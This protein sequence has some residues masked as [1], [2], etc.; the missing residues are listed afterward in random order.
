MAHHFLARLLSIGSAAILGFFSASAGAA[1]NIAN[2]SPRGLTI[3]KPTV[4]V[5][6]GTD[7]TPNTRL[8]LPATIASQTIKSE[9]Q[10]DRLEIEVT[11]DPA[12]PPGLYPLRLAGGKGISGPVMIGV[13]RL[14]QLPFAQQLG[15][16]PV[17][18]HGTLAGT[19]VL[20]ARF[21]GQKD[22]RLVL[23][24][25]AQRLGSSLEPVVRLYD[26]R[27][28]QIA[29][30]PPLPAIG[31]D[32]RC[33]VKLPA[34]GEYSIELHERL[35]RA[36]GPAFFRLKIGDL[37]YADLALPLA[38]AAGSKQA[39]QFASTNLPTGAEQDATGATVPGETVAALPAAENFTGAAPRLAIT[40][41]PE[42][43]ESAAT[44]GKLQELPACPVG[45]SGVLAAKG[46]EDKYLLTVTPGQKL[47]LDVIARQVGSPL[48][49]VL[50]IR[51]EQGKQLATGDDRPAS[52]DPLVDFEVP[53]NVTKLQIALKDLNGSG[54]SEFVYRIDIQDRSRPDFAL[55]LP[56]DRVNVPAGGAQVVPVQVTRTNYAG[57]IELSLAGRPAELT[58]AGN[59]IPPG[60][61]IGLLTLS[62]GNGPPQ[63]VL[64]RVVGKALE[65]PVPVV[66]AA[67]F[68][69]VPGGR[70]QPR[71]REQ[72]GL[73]IAEASPINIVWAPSESDKLMLG[74]KLVAKLQLPRAAGTAGS[75]RVRLLTTQPMPK[76]TVKENNQDKVVDD[77][78]RALRLEGDP[79]FPADQS[80]V[81][82]NILV[83]ADLPRQAWD[84]VLVADLLS[85]DGKNTVASIAAP[86][87]RLSAAVPFTLEL[88]GPAN[89]EG[90]AGAGET[91]KFTGK[92]V[93][94]AGYDQ[95]VTVTLDNLPK[96]LSSPTVI[97][98]ADQSEFALPVTFAFGSKPGE[99]KG[100]KLVALS[101]PVTTQSVRS[102]AVD[103]AVSVVPGEK[104]AA[105]QPKEIF[106]DDE[107]FI[108]LLT[109]GAGRAIP[110]M[111]DKHSGTYSLRVTGDQK[112]N[113]KLPT[114]GMKIRENPAPGEYR[115]IRFAWKKAGGN[116]ICLQL[117]HDGVWGPGGEGARE[118]AKFRYHAG[119]GGE[120]Y[121]AS[122]VISDKLPRQFQVV[123][124]D[125]FADFGEFTLTGLAFSPVDGNAAL[126]DHLYLGRQLEDFT[127][128]KVEKK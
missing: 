71:I 78:D 29:W 96:G 27:G 95:P 54:G 45:I 5:I 97:V 66:R 58:L 16:F 70:Y 53:A 111:R 121:G 8:L 36:A 43:V 34:D 38:V 31:G 107:K 55:S 23:D 39:L 122:L 113:P 77:L 64:S 2:V 124:R 6:T 14:P 84:L 30:S 101:S 73:A 51:D 61:T 83:P 120:C 123:T 50:L 9:A 118:G 89:V 11:L 56:A 44:D 102:N 117:N 28:K 41:H 99:L 1:P 115:Y 40:D 88:A 127:L 109:E 76:K 72:I 10:P 105:E 74:G 103:V 98:P 68:G 81:A 22:Q 85:A 82:V 12:V 13:D 47:R 79:V 110:E 128:L 18:L 116:S 108:A 32:A 52:S 90:K 15:P 112:L 67:M 100:V 7:L 80:D 37:Q 106:E 46:E 19:Q 60:A 92:V 25:E 35:Y 126:F 21:T 57:A 75:I 125:L 91:G 48:D 42:L 4:L 63:A 119:P 93:R 59:V 20:Q 26:A 87:R 62:A 17:A 104:P 49:G 33:E 24:V 69:D 86:V 65:S 94:A 3:G 114:L